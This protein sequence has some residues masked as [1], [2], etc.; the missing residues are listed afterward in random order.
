MGCAHAISSPSSV[1]IRTT[2]TR[3]EHKLIVCEGPD[4][5]G[6]STLVDTLSDDLGLEIGV[7]GVADRSKLYEVT[8]RDTYT[9]LSEAVKGNA[10]PKI[11]DRL[12]FSELVY[13]PMAGRTSEFDQEESI[14]IK[15]VMQSIGCPVIVC[16]P[17]WETV[18]KN[19]EGTEQMAGVHENLESIYQAYTSLFSGMSWIM[20]YDYTGT[21]TF[22]E[23]DNPLHP[24]PRGSQKTYEQ[25]VESLEYYIAD[26]Q[27]RE[28]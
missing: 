12:F 13:A 9:A 6:K 14:I 24:S 2:T 22:G 8:R 4:G 20:W 19:V 11:W 7:R 10:K 28:W 21:H 15:R 17:P 23:N 16:L 5:A 25:L 18:K 3:R 1:S 26:R 27:K